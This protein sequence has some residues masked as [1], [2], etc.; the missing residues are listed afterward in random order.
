MMSASSQRS[1]SSAKGGNVTIDE[2]SPFMVATQMSMDFFLIA[3]VVHYSMYLITC[4]K[5]YLPR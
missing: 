1:E 4:F 5:E 2:L 3:I